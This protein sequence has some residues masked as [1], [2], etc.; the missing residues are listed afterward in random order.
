M[1]WVSLSV[2]A[3]GAAVTTVVLGL[4]LGIEAFAVGLVASVVPVPVLVLAFLWLGRYEPGPGSYLAFCFGWGAVVA[5]AVA[6]GVNTGAA[7]LFDRLDWFWGLVA[8]VVAPVI[9]ELG[10]AAA[11]LLLWWRRRAVTGITRGIVYCGLS[12]T[13]FAMVENVLYLGGYGYRTGL[14]E[15]GRA[16]GLQLVFIIFIARILMSGFAHPLFTAA[17]GVGIGAASRTPRVAVRWLAVTGGLLAAMVL[18]AAW[19]LMSVLQ[20]ETGEQLFLLYGYVAVMLPILVGMVGLAIWL[21]SWEGQLTQRVLPE[22]VR[23]GWLS[24]PEVAAL[25][26]L[27]T[28]HSARRWARRVAGDAGRQA[29]RRFQVA[30][31]R[32]ALLRDEV[33]R[34]LGTS[35]QRAERMAAEERALLD[36]LVESRAVFAGRD[37]LVPPAWW[38]GTA[39]RITFPDGETRTVPAPPEPVMPVPVQLAPPPPPPPPWAAPAAWPHR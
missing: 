14:E 18:H 4:A 23:A 35:P 3:L 21:R 29:M 16:T 32:L 30:A 36:T 19:N 27:G 34:G 33:R 15:Y 22:Y 25:R 38:D 9:E 2:I 10:K 12:A 39:Y 17:A 37:P 5:T 20:A 11:P 6:M 31:T 13:G 24:P 7:W 8:V 28:R 1:F 26:S